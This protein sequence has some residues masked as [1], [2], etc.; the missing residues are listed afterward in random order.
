V[1]RLTLL[2][3]ALA[4]AAFPAADPPPAAEIDALVKSCGVTPDGPGLA[5]LVLRN[6]RPVVEKC[7]GLANLENKTLVTPKTTFELASLT[8]PLTAV[9]LLHQRGR[10]SLEDDVRKH[11]PELPEP[12]QG[13][14]VRM[15]DLL[16]HTSGLPDYMQFKDVK[17]AHPGYLTNDDYLKAWARYPAKEPP[18]ERYRYNN[19]NYLLL[20]SVVERASTKSFGAFLHD[21]VF[22]PLGM[23]SSWVYEGPDAAAKAPAAPRAV[24]YSRPKKDGAYEPTWG[25]PPDRSE[26]LLTVGDGGVWTNLEDLARFDAGLRENRL[27]KPET[28]RLALEPSKTRDGKTNPCG[29]GWALVRDGAGRTAAFFHDGAWQGFRTSFHHNRD[30]GRTIILLSNRGDFDPSK[31]KT[32]FFTKP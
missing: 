30:T 13:R 18:G 31:L 6:G 2:L 8:K 1:T 27:L 4:L 25:S 28:L 10:L 26:E 16:H 19:S 20:A 11:L 12:P 7:Y 15:S 3:P 21:E 32:I 24:G 9:L 17:G 5:M 29:L 23:N 14:P 22:R